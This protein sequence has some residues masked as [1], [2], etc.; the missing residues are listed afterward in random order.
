MQERQRQFMQAELSR[1]LVRSD[2]PSFLFALVTSPFHL[3][4]EFENIP[5]CWLECAQLTFPRILILYY[6]LMG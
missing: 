4:N 3:P 5:L 6:Q 2:C 1:S